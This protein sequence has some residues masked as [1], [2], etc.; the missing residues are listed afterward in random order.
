MESIIY[1]KFIDMN[2][3]VM[4]LRWWELEL[5]PKPNELNGGIIGLH[6]D[7]RIFSI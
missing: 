7:N 3:Q 5:I 6:A 4:N 2:L 1:S